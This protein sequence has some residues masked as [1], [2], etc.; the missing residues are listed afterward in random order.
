[1]SDRRFCVSPVNY[2]DPDLDWTRN[3]VHSE[4]RIRAKQQPDVFVE[5]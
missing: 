3:T 5:C 2:P 1:M 4:S